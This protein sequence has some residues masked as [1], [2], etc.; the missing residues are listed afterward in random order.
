MKN[1]QAWK[2]ELLLLVEEASDD[3]SSVATKDNFPPFS[4]SFKNFKNIKKKT[5]S[6]NYD[7]AGHAY[8]RYGE[9]R[10]V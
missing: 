2:G 7:I 10:Y 8:F 3:A 1:E 4:L 5:W 6:V 9:S